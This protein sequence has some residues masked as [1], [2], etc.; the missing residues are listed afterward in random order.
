MCLN[1]QPRDQFV[2]KLMKQL[3]T[4]G[5]ADTLVADAAAS[6][7]GGSDV[8]DTEESWENFA[9]NEEVSNDDL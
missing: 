7:S 1:V 8:S 9:D 6:D 4:S 3:N 2:S 5:G